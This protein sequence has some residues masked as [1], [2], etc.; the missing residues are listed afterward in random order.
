MF[1]N[2]GR[3]KD[4]RWA[5]VAVMVLC[6]LVLMFSFAAKLSL[7]QP[8]NSQ[9]KALASS[10]MWQH[11]AQDAAALMAAPD[12]PRPSSGH[13]AVGLSVTLVMVAATFLRM[14]SFATVEW[15]EREM[16]IAI[17]LREL[18][19]KSQLRAPPVR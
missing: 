7:Y 17:Q 4:E 19:S 9:I 5:R 2:F 8:R 10:K 12:E 16:P 11:E 3:T 6:L 18:A 13:V 15:L 14:A 1:L